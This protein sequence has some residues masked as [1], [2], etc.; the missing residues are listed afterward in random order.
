M[1]HEEQIGEADR[2]PCH[3]WMTIQQPVNLGDADPSVGDGLDN[4]IFIDRPIDARRDGAI[5]CEGYRDLPH[6]VPVGD[7]HQLVHARRSAW[8]LR[9]QPRAG[10]DGINVA[11]DR[12]R[13]VQHPAVMLERGDAA[14]RVA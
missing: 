14:E 10:R 5:A 6:Y 7:A 2:V 3:P 1:R 9:L 8:L 13:L 12:L 4:S 11:H